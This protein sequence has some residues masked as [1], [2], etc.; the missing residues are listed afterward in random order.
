MSIS[1]P[2][3]AELQYYYFG[4]YSVL[5]RY[6]TAT[7]LGWLIVLLG[8]VAIPL[9]WEFGRNHGLIDLVLSVCTIVAGLTVVQL[10]VVSLGDYVS[11]PFPQE[12]KA[13]GADDEHPGLVEIKQL[14]N[15]IDEGGWQEAYAGIG[16]IRQLQEKYAFPGLDRH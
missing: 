3:D 5:K 15:E 12:R 4:L 1:Q 14:M 10:S 8:A 16:K 2:S 13:N 6:R 11:I 7:L 9:G